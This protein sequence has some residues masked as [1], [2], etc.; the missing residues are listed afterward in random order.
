MENGSVPQ[1]LLDQKQKLNK[2]RPNIAVAYIRVSDD[3]QVDNESLDTQKN[4]IQQYADR[5]ELEI[6]RWFGDEGKSAKTVS[7]RDDMM[8]M[9]NYCAANKGQIGYA[10]FY[11]MKRASRDAPSYYSDFKTILTGLGM[12]VRSATEH[13]DD[14]P[15]GRFI[16]GVLVLNGQLDNEVKGVTTTDNMQ[17]VARQ[18][19][20]QHGYLY[21]YDLKRMKVGV[22]K[23]HTTLKRNR[24]WEKV[25]DLF[26]TYAKGGF[27]QADIKRM[28]KEKGLKSFQGKYPD[29]NGIYRMLTQ[30]AYAGYICS[31]HT[32]WEMYEGKHLQEAIV[33]LETFQRVQQIINAQSRNRTGT[34]VVVANELFPLKR[35]VRCFNCNNFL[36]ASS[37]KTGGGK[38]YSPRYHCARKQCVG[39]V[40]S[41]SA[42]KANEAFNLLLQDIQPA[43]STL[44]LYKE[45]LNRTA[46]KQLDNLNSRLST[47]RTALSLLDEERSI[48]MRRWNKGEMDT[49]DKDE[50]IIRVEA[51]RFE[52]KDQ[53]A[54]L[55]A[56]Q[57][58]KK[59]QID[60]A[61]NFMHDAYKLWLDADVDLR[62]KFQKAIFPEGVILDTK[63]LKF[64]TQTI[65]PLYRYILNK[66]DLSVSEKSLVVTLPGIEPGLQG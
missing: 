31:K 63:T 66:K 48:A 15:A 18:G 26:E 24:D 11:N 53:I 45:I 30:P 55:E 56:Q 28:A 27:T 57:A 14:T 47:L 7:K 46:M 52:K 16:E 12:A 29:D 13:I 35:F 65:S 22:K 25:R 59:S 34:K 51:D 32:N 17:S 40:P 49:E 6:I 9:L 21:G 43:R 19:W 39:V 20:W 42:S 41:I 5:N 4:L 8:T 3:G 37:P 10:I 33:S 61:M 2:K 44:K 58:I 60:Y 64:G 50:I 36:Y 38:S 1:R 62:Q 54:A 23:K